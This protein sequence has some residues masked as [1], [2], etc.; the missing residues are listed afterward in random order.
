MRR[1][2]ALSSIAFCRASKSSGSPRRCRL[3]KYL[4]ERAIAG[5][6]VKEYSIGVDVFGKPPDYDPRID[7]A[8][9][10]EVGRMKARLAEY[11]AGEGNANPARIEFPKEVMRRRFAVLS[12]RCHR[13]IRRPPLFPPRPIDG[14]SG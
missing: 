7:P 3:L 8:V 11:Y 4:V 10:V 14:F 9:R 1:L 12:L 5:E 13:P 2:F 6:P